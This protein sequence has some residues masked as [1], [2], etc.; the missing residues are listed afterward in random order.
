[1]ERVVIKFGGT[2]L[3]SSAALRTAITVLQEH[4]AVPRH[5]VGV[6]SAMSGVTDLLLNSAQQAAQGNPRVF[7]EAAVTLQARHAAMLQELRADPNG[8]II[9]RINQLIR[10]FTLQ[11][12]SLTVLQELTP[13]ASDSI[14]SLGE[15]MNVQVVAAALQ[16]SGQLALAIDASDCIVTDSCFGSAN[17]LMNET[18]RRTRARLLPLLDMGMVPIVTGFIGATP[19]GSTS[20]LGRG[21]SDFSA[22]LIG[23]AIDANE[24]LIYTDVD[25]VMTSDPRLIS[26]ATVIPALSYAEVC[27]LAA[28][29][30]KVLHP[31]TIWPLMQ[32]NIPLWTGN[33]F[34]RHHPGTIITEAG[35][36]LV[37]L[38]KAVT[39]LNNLS[40]ITIQGR[41]AARAADLESY[42]S[43][44]AEISP[45]KMVAIADAPNR[46][47]TYVVVRSDAVAAIVAKLQ[48]HLAADLRSGQIYS[49]TAQPDVALVS[50][51]GRGSL[52]LLEISEEIATVLEA[53]GFDV[54]AVIAGHSA[55]SSS[56]V[57]PA[58]SAVATLRF[59][60]HSFIESE[61]ELFQPLAAVLGA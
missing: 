41:P 59:I 58:S 2:S 28:L 16:A 7:Q 57:V 51:I 42:L 30:A 55:C 25:G 53:E 15:R 31:A 61:Q 37:G 45:A 38:I 43:K 13:Q 5:V 10:T 8:V 36:G 1:M 9:H 40:L 19:N 24:V 47:Q 26:E 60:H 14:A 21:G 34:N 35:S 29:G 33:T 18:R 23:A 11:C 27:D 12:G 56:V 20:T 49:I 32:Q 17:P 3:G 44:S 48:A 4:I 39:L 52:Y 6:V 54:L 50:V 22:A 46:Q